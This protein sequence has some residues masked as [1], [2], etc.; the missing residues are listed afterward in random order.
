MKDFFPIYINLKGK[1]CLVVGGGTVAERKIK[2]IIGFAPAVTV[3]APSVTKG[4]AAL[5]ENKKIQWRP[6]EFKKSDISNC[7]LVFAATNDEPLNQKIAETCRK[8][9]ILVNA[10]KPG[11]SGSFI[12]P[13]VTAGNEISVVVS[14]S[15]ASPMIARL[16]K[17]EMEKRIAI[18]EKLLAVIKPFRA[19]L[20]TVNGGS[21]YN[22]KFWNDFFEHPVLDWIEKGETEKVK[23]LAGKIFLNFKDGKR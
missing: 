20:L 1:K 7:F 14:T 21:H 2:N 6:G 15:G 22:K 3:V 16:L 8:Q 12:V 19:R 11:L 18:Y 17:A 5:A 10:A 13:A 4:I 23:K 9:N